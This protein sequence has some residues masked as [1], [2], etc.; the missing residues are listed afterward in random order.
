MSVKQQATGGWIKDFPEPWIPVPFTKRT[1][2]RR[3]PVSVPKIIVNPF[4]VT[5]T[6]SPTERIE[7]TWDYMMWEKLTSM[8]GETV[9]VKDEELAKM[10]R[11][12]VDEIRKVKGNVN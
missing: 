10:A 1:E 9:N 5:S 8:A 11:A 4:V 12:R 6:P 7:N 3:E 2:K